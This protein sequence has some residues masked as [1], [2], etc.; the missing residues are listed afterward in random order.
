MVEFPNSTADLLK[1]LDKKSLELEQMKRE[2]DFAQ[3]LEA[4][5]ERVRS[6]TLNMNKSE[7]LFDV[8]Q[9]ILDQFTL[10]FKSLR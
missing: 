4:A 7:E 6:V 9:L 3:A 1:Q 5:L 8:I 10:C 2:H